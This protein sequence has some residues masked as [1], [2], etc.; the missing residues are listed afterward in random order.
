MKPVYFEPI[1][2]TYRIGL[3]YKIPRFVFNIEHMCS[4]GVESIAFYESYNRI[5]VRYTLF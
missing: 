2:A 1:Q 5:S 3:L 4:H